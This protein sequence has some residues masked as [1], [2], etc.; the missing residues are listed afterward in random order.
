MIGIHH[1]KESS[2]ETTANSSEATTLVA[3]DDSQ[4]KSTMSPSPHL[5]DP[6]HHQAKTDDAEEPAV[7][8][9]PSLAKNKVASS[10]ISA[11]EADL[12]DKEPS[13]DKNTPSDEDSENSLQ[14]DCAD[15]PATGNSQEASSIQEPEAADN[16]STSELSPKEE[17]ADGSEAESP[18]KDDVQQDEL[19]QQQQHRQP[20]S[21]S[22]SSTHPAQDASGKMCSQMSLA[23][24]VTWMVVFSGW[25][26]NSCAHWI[27][28]L[29]THSF[30]S[31]HH[32]CCGSQAPA[33]ETSTAASGSRQYAETVHLEEGERLS[34]Y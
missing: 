27:E 8:T 2:A 25:R 12:I 16:A 13:E 21:F 4:T 20:S 5:D 26:F 19:E 17:I 22:Y 23:Q 28:S 7:A 29:I 32:S 1:N 6:L 30:V 15:P 10:T 18:A 9:A 31:G 34:V 14:E 11:Q 24:C 33:E 3:T